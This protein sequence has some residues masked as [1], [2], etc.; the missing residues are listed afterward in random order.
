M[1][2]GGASG[3]GKLMGQIMAK[4][5]ATI[6]IWDIDE[7]KLKS[8]AK[9]IKDAGGNV[10]TNKCDITDRKLVYRTAQKVKEKVG[11]VDILINNAGIVTGK[12]FWECT[13]E[14]LQA[15]MDVNTM[16][17]FWTVKAFLPDMIEANSGHLVTI[18][19]AAGMVG[20]TRLTDYNASK[21]AAFGFDESL[22]MEFR[23]RKMNIRTTII[24]PY[25]I[26]TGMFKGVK[27]RFPRLLPILEEDVVA[28]KIVKAIESNKA[29]LIMPGLVYSSWIM[30]YLPVSVF[31][32][33]SSFLGVSTAMDDFIGREN[34]VS[35]NG[36]QKLADGKAQASG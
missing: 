31:D 24:C 5:G 2:T 18:S 26:N 33:I 8:A 15:T 7:K 34:D 25:F 1:I 16:G 10:I 12:P 22:R 32:W 30:R 14:E 20:A 23:R 21:F 13:D 19:S 11:N 4:K 27:T 6:I 9:E 28:R 29:R 3:I 17:L 35:P 36:R